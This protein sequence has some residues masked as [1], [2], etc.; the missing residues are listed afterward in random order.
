[1]NHSIDCASDL[2]LGATAIAE[3]LG[4][5]RRQVYRLTQLPTFKVGGTIAARRSSLNRWMDDAER[6]EQA[7]RAIAA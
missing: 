6:A 3:H 2:L 5:N 4:V 1:M 7:A